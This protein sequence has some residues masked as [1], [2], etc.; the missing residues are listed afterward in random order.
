[1]DPDY[2]LFRF[3]MTPYIVVYWASNGIWSTFKDVGKEDVPKEVNKE[4]SIMHG[5]EIAEYWILFVHVCPLL[6]H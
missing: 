4:S 5:P 1:M 6:N 2:I 3:L